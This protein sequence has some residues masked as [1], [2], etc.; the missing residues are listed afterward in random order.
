MTL[1][2]INNTYFTD[3]D[4]CADNPCWKGTCTDLVAGYKCICQSGYTGQRCDEGK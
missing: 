1:N 4:E 2:I 3:I